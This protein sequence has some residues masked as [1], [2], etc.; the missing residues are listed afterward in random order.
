M[1]AQSE[2]GSIGECIRTCMKTVPNRVSVR[3]EEGKVHL[4]GSS[5]ALDLLDASVS[6]RPSC[7]GD[8][9]PFHAITDNRLIT[10]PN[11]ANHFVTFIP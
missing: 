4:N 2:V 1:K 11:F 7:L 10:R 8:P 3:G 6:C 5:P 9:Q